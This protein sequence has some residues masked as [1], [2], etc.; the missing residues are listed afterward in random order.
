MTHLVDDVGAANEGICLSLGVQN[1][2]HFHRVE[3]RG[4][5]EDILHQRVTAKQFEDKANQKPMPTTT[6][7]HQP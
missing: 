3:G 6:Q 4:A 1:G 2:A 7:K 5:L